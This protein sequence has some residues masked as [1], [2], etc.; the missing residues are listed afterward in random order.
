M[1]FGEKILLEIEEKIDSLSLEDFMRLYE[2]SVNYK[3]R[4]FEETK[5]T[6]FEFTFLSNESKN[7][8][9]RDFKPIEFKN[10]SLSYDDID[11]KVVNLY[12]AA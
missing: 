12:F 2:E 1:N 9:K 5:E 11:L 4:F 8:N 3:N 6:S 10:Y 7:L